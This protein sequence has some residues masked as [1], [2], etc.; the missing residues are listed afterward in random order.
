MRIYSVYVSM[1]I[2][3]FVCLYIHA[4]M[5]MILH[6]CDKLPVPVGQEITVTGLIGAREY[7]YIHTLFMFI[8]TYLYYHDLCM[9]IHKYESPY[10]YHFAR[11]F[12][13]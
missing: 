3:V 11:M 12:W 4:R 6:G 5:R 2:F 13:S 7:A 9:F 10:P 1:Y 8:C